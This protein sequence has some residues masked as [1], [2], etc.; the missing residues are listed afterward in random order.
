V[1][2]SYLLSGSFMPE[3]GRDA[4][5]LS[6]EYQTRQ[7]AADDFLITGIDRLGATIRASVS[8]RARPLVVVSNGDSV[9]LIRRFVESMQQQ[10]SLFGANKWWVCLVTSVANPHSHQLNDLTVIAQSST[11]SDHFRE[12]A[13]TAGRTN[14]SSRERLAQLDLI[15]TAL[16]SN[17]NP[18]TWTA[19]PQQLTYELLVHLRVRTVHLEGADEADRIDAVNRL[20]PMSASSDGDLLFLRLEELSDT[21]AMSG[22]VISEEKLRAD[23][24]SLLADDYLVAT[25]GRRV[26]QEPV[27]VR[28]RRS[29]RASLNARRRELR[30]TLG[31]DDEQVDRSFINEPTIPAELDALARGQVLAIRGPVGSGKSDLAIRWLLHNSSSAVL[32]GAPVPVWIAADSMTG[33]IEST[34][35]D[36]LNRAAVDRYPLDVVIDGVDERIDGRIASEAKI[37]AAAHST[38]RIILTTREGET[39]PGNTAIYNISRWDLEESKALIARIAGVEAWRVGHGWTESLLDTIRRPLFALIAGRHY[40]HVGDSAVGLIAL[41]AREAAPNV[42]GSQSLESLAV[43]AVRANGPV[44]PRAAHLDMDLLRRSRLVEMAGGRMRFTL[45][46]FEQWFAAHAVLGGAVD[47]AEFSG[48]ALGFA[49][50][51]Y[52]LALAVTAGTR[53]LVNPMMSALVRSN[54]GA[55]AWVIREGMSNA[56]FDGVAVGHWRDAGQSILAAMDSWFDGLR[57]LGAGLS[58]FTLAQVPE[59]E[60]VDALQLILLTGERAG[61][62]YVS[63]GW[64][65]RDPQHDP[66]LVEGVRPMEVTLPAGSTGGYRTVSGENWVWEWSLDEVRRRLPALLSDHSLLAALI[67]TGVVHREYLSWLAGAIMGRSPSLGEQI[68]VSEIR[69]KIRRLRE[70][71]PNHGHFTV[72]QTSVGRYIWGSLELLEEAIDSEPTDQFVINLYSPPDLLPETPLQGVQRYSSQRIGERAV[73]VVSQAAVAYT[74]IADTI[75]PKF[76]PLLA[77][78][79]TFPAVMRGTVFHDVNGMGGSGITHLSYTWD[80]NSRSDDS[81]PLVPQLDIF[82]QRRTI[83]SDIEEESTPR[84]YPED[85]ARR[86]FGLFG[87]ATS[88]TLDYSLFGVRPATA[89][90]VGWIADDLHALG[91]LENPLRRPIR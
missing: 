28:H 12:L 22:A 20:T 73:D 1:L 31:L 34:I 66:A 86:A 26:G 58:P 68:G 79:A 90:A 33:T 67:R 30:S 76:G 88:T 84:S 63:H 45:P 42:P 44:D 2:L 9:K 41:A 19:D 43:A 80:D 7:T 70:A 21:Y 72:M 55:A 64:T 54:P 60:I 57:P 16:L 51:R 14:S 39:L 46:I 4:S 77:H 87:T 37:F 75:F 3:L 81:R 48:G 61:E 8:A 24:G 89:M 29:T 47:P 53:E 36:L 10:P 13:A 52:V 5:P 62:S 49:K 11:S 65:I 56:L 18:V 35:A 74:E 91:W 82:A 6:V 85:P 23:L 71:H 32:A 27:V 69:T 15:S 50:W 17:D 83:W 40:E 78:N 59:Q 38:T 25:S